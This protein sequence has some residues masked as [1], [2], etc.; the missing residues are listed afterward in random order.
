MS[1][2][3]NSF[4]SFVESQGQPLL[5]LSLYVSTQNYTNITRPIYNTIQSFPRPYV[6]PPAVRA[7]AKNRTE[8]LGLSSLDIDSEDVNPT[9]N[10][11]IIPE[12]LRLPRQT[13]T[14]LLAAAPENKA[15]IRLDS[16]ASNFFTPLQGLRSSKRFFLSSS[17]PSS[18]DC[19][20]FGYLS[21]CLLPDLPQPWLART[22]RQKFPQLCA[23]VHELQRSFFGGP[24][25]VVDAF[26][27]K[28]N[29]ADKGNL[30]WSKPE[31]GGLLAIGGVMA[32]GIVDSIPG[33]AA[34]RRITRLQETP[35]EEMDDEV[36]LELARAQ[37][38][39][40]E[41][42]TTIG[43]VAAGVVLLVGFLFHQGFI[44]LHVDDS[45]AL[46]QEQ[47]QIFVDDEDDSNLADVLSE[48]GDLNI[49]NDLARAFGGF[50]ASSNDSESGIG[51][52]VDV[53]V[54]PDETVR[55]RVV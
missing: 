51:V 29:S 1:L 39:R 55:D 9:N 42:L 13:V 27:I 35:E 38:Q 36:E 50:P 22:M 53:A 2:I 20:A 19:L 30:P 12:S 14:S 21:L 28:Y 3:S 45:S 40:K 34:W 17:E 18:L 44:A 15:Q 24:C 52:D 48:M 46:E 26:H 37:Y 31:A 7:A 54:A 10:K 32:A 6:T 23:F 41:L 43:S 47:K 33:V 4:S 16:L 8:Y 11:S 49:Q 25:S 5:D